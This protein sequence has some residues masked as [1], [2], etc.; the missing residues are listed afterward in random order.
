MKQHL[1]IVESPAKCKKIEKLLGKEYKC[2]ASYGH[3]CELNELDQIDFY[4]Y[5][6]NNYKIIKEK[7]KNLNFLKDTINKVQLNGKEVII[8]TD[9]DREGEG[10]GYYLCQFCDLSIHNT[11]RILFNEITKSAL[12]YSI[13]NP[14]KLDIKLIHS[15][16]TR[17]IL[18]LCLGFKI[19]PLLWKHVYYGLSAGRCQTPALN[20][21]YDNEIELKNYIKSPIFQWN[22]IGDFGDKHWDF[23]LIYNDDI[24]K[25]CESIKSFLN[26]CNS[27]DFYCK[28]IDNEKLDNRY[29][30]LPLITSSLQ[31]NCNKLFG[32][33][34]KMTMKYAQDLYENGLIT[35]MRTDSTIMSKDFIDKTINFIKNK[36]GQEFVSSSPYSRTN[37]KSKQKSQEA[38]ECIRVTNPEVITLNESKFSD[39][40]KVL[41]EY[42]WKISIQ[43]LMS[44]SQYYK[45]ILS[46]DAPQNTYFQKNFSL[47]KFKGFEILNK[48]NTDEKMVNEFN[49]INNFL[50]SN[51]DKILIKNHKITCQNDLIK[52]PKL[53]NEP[54]LIKK[55][56][57]HNIGR[58]STY[59][60]IIQSL[61]NKYLDKV[62]SQIIDVI[63]IN[64]IVL[65]NNNINDEI[66]KK[67][68]IEQNKY[69][70]NEK[71]IK[72]LQFCIKYFNSLFNY[73]FTNS[74]ET[75]LDLIAD[76]SQN[77]YDVCN[78]YNN[79]ID[80]C[81]KLVDDK[82]DF[83]LKQKNSKINIGKYE[84]NSIYL[85]FG[86]Y[87]YYL[88]HKKEKFSISDN[89][90]SHNI[91]ISDV[92][93]S[94]NDAIDIINKQREDKD[95]KIVR[96]INNDIS[97]RKS[98][99]GEYIFYKT[100]K[101]KKP[102]F[103]NLK[104]FKD[105]DYNDCNEEYIINYVNAEKNNF[106]KRRKFYKK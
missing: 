52:I 71:G 5:E 81:I 25:D 53:L 12:T 48:T 10:I 40:H 80:E 76:G 8:A 101:M 74:L 17:Q 51:R 3:I 30:P 23:N 69:K 19:S 66:Y 24:F 18:D 87:G 72:S 35:Y 91:D 105:H 85:N 59:A 41:Y 43:T 7:Q 93:F 38:H 27:Y 73:D 68:I 36:Y 14:K 6:D 98:D 78:N 4:K 82:N 88:E 49:Y 20:M 89:I 32:Y 104:N 28:N 47:N 1:I 37:N 79:K 34:S 42:I 39:S 50:F 44:N 100:N 103:I 31:Q 29:P 63:D 60:S 70:I 16:Q 46:I 77:K 61:E 9:N 99:Y 55:M 2:V 64:K 92:E 96:I 11:K 90:L 83:K 102:K 62:K 56:E 106:K 94:I 54:N 75:D 65:Q 84:N 15:Q 67:E 95:N 21:I 58:P 22:I 33:T 45:K 13:N 97:I 26:N 57:T 86:S